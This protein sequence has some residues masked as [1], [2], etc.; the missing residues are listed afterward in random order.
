MCDVMG[1]SPPLSKGH[2][3]LFTWPL[4][5]CWPPPVMSATSTNKAIH[6]FII[7]SKLYEYLNTGSHEQSFSV[8]LA[9]LSYLEMLVGCFLLL[10][11][12]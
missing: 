1:G 2:V 11:F 12:L 6:L 9:L 8:C 5:G 4:E 10:L 3:H 7:S